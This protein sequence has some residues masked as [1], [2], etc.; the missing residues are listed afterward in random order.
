MSIKVFWKLAQM[1]SLFFS[2]K[3]GSLAISSLTKYNKEVFTP[4][5]L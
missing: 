1:S 4:E 2:M 5:K 3:S